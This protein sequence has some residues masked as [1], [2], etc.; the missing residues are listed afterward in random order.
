MKYE[1]NEKVNALPS[2]DSVES[3]LADNEQILWQGKP[4]KSAYI[5]NKVFAMMPIALLFLAFDSVFIL[6]A[7][8]FKM[9]VY[10]KIAILVFVCIHLV[11]FW[12]WL[13]NVLTANKRY[14][15][16]Q[17][18][19]TSHRILIKTGLIGIDFQ[20]VSYKDVQRVNLKVGAVDKMLKVGDLYFECANNR[21]QNVFFDI[22]NPYEVYKIAQKIV[23]AIQTDIQFP[24]AYR[25]ENNPGYNTKMDV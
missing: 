9:P 22:E 19:L 2:Q 1:K 21:G 4:K 25:P 3:I 11:P 12:M 23:S 7:F 8:H 18:V 16:T 20:S 5:L 24:N 6:S 17:Y 13:S 15:N 10:A 14:K